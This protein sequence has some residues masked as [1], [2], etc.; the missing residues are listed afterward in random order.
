MATFEFPGQLL[1][2]LFMSYEIPGAAA[3]ERAH[4][5]AIEH[6]LPP[7]AG[8]AAMDMAKASP[9]ERSRAYTP[10]QPKRKRKND[11]IA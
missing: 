2:N 4:Y 6:G 9:S 1:A 8:G 11:F 10:C 7:A 3:T 5:T